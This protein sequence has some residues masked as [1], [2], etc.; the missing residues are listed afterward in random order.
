MAK[1][2]ERILAVVVRD[3]GAFNRAMDREETVIVVESPLYDEVKGVLTVSKGGQKIKI[4]SVIGGAAGIAL[5]GLL[6]AGIILASVAGGVVGSVMDKSKMY[7][8]NNIDVVRKR[9]ILTKSVGKNKYIP[10]KHE[11]VIL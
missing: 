6:G 2:K 5:G 3:R 10:S 8:V 1:A 4:G 7:A 11:L 9:I